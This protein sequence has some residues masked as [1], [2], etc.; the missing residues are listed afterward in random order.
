M[1]DVKGA[2]FL[3]EHLSNMGYSSDTGMGRV[4]L[5][6]T[7]IKAYMQCVNITFTPSEV[8]LIKKMSEAFTYQTYD[9]NPLANPPYVDDELFI[10]KNN[11]QEIKDK[12]A[13]F[14]W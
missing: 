7:E 9:K 6:F 10:P 3:I 5:S 12:F 8:L 4:P 13:I 14:G 1:P 2:Q 11:S